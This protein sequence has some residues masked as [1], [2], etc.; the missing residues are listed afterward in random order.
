MVVGDLVEVALVSPGPGAAAAGDAAEFRVWVAAT[1]LDLKP[2]EEPVL[3]AVELT[4]GAC[5]A[6]LCNLAIK[7]GLRPLNSALG[8]VE[9]ETGG[10]QGGGQGGGPGPAVWADVPLA[11]LRIP[12]RV[13]PHGLFGTPLLKRA[14]VRAA[15]RRKAERRAAAP[16]AAPFTTVV[17]KEVVQKE[18]APEAPEAPEGVATASKRAAAAASFPFQYRAAAAAASF[19]PLRDS[20]ESDAAAPIP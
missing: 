8:K 9:K 15:K 4:S 1:V 10:G 7:S 16:S 3:A 2:P 13:S 12:S 14:L 11:R 5:S 18:V 17:Q 19:P 6:K 20:S